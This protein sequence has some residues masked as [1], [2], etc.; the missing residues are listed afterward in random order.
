MSTLLFDRTYSC[1]GTPVAFRGAVFPFLA[2]SVVK[3][4]T[5]VQTYPRA[6]LPHKFITTWAGTEVVFVTCQFVEM[7]NNFLVTERA[8][9]LYSPP[10]NLRK[11]HNKNPLRGA[12][13]LSRPSGQRGYNLRLY[14]TFRWPR[15][16]DYSMGLR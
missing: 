16:L 13:W 2:C 8:K 3:G 15:H 9:S 1:F 7:N 6:F 5:A 12:D 14:R 10:S 4:Q 11:C